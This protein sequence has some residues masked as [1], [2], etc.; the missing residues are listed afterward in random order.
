MKHDF[1]FVLAVSFDD[2]IAIDRRVANAPTV[3]ASTSMKLSVAVWAKKAQ[4]RWAVVLV[5]SVDVIQDEAKRLAIPTWVDRRKQARGPITLIW[6]AFAYP[7]LCVR[8]SNRALADWLKCVVK[9][10]T[11]AESLSVHSRA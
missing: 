1:G 6:F 11:D 4:V 9:D 5:V 3:F 10:L 2:T 8:P 7:P